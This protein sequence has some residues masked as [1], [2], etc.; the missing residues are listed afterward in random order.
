M[1]HC[2]ISY[3]HVVSEVSRINGFRHTS[4]AESSVCRL[5]TPCQ[6]KEL[7]FLAIDP[8]SIFS[9]SPCTADS[10]LNWFRARTYT[11]TKPESGT[12]SE[13]NSIERLGSN[14]CYRKGVSR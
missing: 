7:G 13:L 3:G 9:M 12:T 4:V 14:S 2:C 6:A 10:N 5:R 1:G 11:S 8:A